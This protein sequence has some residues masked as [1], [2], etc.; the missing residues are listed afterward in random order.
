MRK[1]VTLTLGG[2]FSLSAFFGGYSCALEDQNEKTG[3]SENHIYATSAQDRIDLANGNLSFY[4]PIF[5]V[6]EAAGVC[7]QVGLA[8]NSKAWDLADHD[9]TSGNAWVVEPAAKSEV[10]LGFQLRPG[11]IYGSGNFLIYED[12]TGAP[13]T[14][15]APA[16]EQDEGMREPDRVPDDGLQAGHVSP[17]ALERTERNGASRRGDPRRRFRRWCE[18]SRRLIKK[19][20]TQLLTTY[21]PHLSEGVP[22]DYPTLGVGGSG[23]YL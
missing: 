16:H 3:F 9:G 1:L 20:Q 13:H 2:V 14:L 19:S 23:G 6:E 10:G 4:V 11:R 15:C 18:E 7:L 8:Y 5:S 12:E 17:E 21:I 22:V